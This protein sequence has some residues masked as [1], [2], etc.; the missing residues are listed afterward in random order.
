MKIETKFDLGQHVWVIRGMVDEDDG[1]VI[2]I[3]DDTI[4]NIEI[5]TDGTF[6]YTMETDM[7]KTEDELLDYNISDKELADLVRT[8]MAKIR[9]KSDERGRT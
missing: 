2:Q 4:C 7:E 9:A 3:Y 1:D 6:Y 5:N 8:N